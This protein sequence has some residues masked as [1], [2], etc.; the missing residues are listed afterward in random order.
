M[1]SAH[2]APL[3][4][5]PLRVD[6]RFIGDY[7]VY[8]AE[9]GAIALRHDISPDDLVRM[10]RDLRERSELVL[11]ASDVTAIEARIH[12]I[13][14]AGEPQPVAPAPAPAGRDA[15][16]LVQENYFGFNIVRAAGR[17]YA[18]AQQVGPIDL[19]TVDA[20]TLQDARLV[21]VADSARDAL[22]MVDGLRLEATLAHSAANTATVT[23][24][25]RDVRGEDRLHQAE[26]QVEELREQLVAS[27]RD[28][29]NLRETLRAGEAERAELSTWIA[30]LQQRLTTAL[31]G[32]WWP[33]RMFRR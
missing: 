16:S 12:E 4:T 19:T 23:A 31:G 10:S 6:V 3:S 8:N 33:L 1:H 15:S 7:A 2:L 30:E 27:G 26:H 20:S 28:R 9:D 25:Q 22:L 11:V 21:L 29:D 18:V 14:T 24:L 32:R 5:D 13:A 17:Y